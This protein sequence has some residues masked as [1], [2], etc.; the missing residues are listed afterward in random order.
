MPCAEGRGPEAR[1]LSQSVASP[2]WSAKVLAAWNAPGPVNCAESNTP[3]SRL[4]QS[5]WLV[6]TITLKRRS[7]CRR[8]RQPVPMP[9]QAH[10]K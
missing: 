6:V 5:H 10:G 7:A 4:A 8:S 2:L 3:L 1:G 9:M